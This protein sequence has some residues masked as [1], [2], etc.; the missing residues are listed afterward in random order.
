M[1]KLFLKTNA[2]SQM[3]PM[4]RIKKILYLYAK[5]ICCMLDIAKIIYLYRGVNK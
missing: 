3:A 2:I 1:L 5:I 4:N